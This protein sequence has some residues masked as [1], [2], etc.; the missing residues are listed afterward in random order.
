MFS[1]ICYSK[2]TTADT[3]IIKNNKIFDKTLLLGTDFQGRVI[4][5]LSTPQ[6][7]FRVNK[8][9]Q[10]GP[11]FFPAFWWNYETGEMDTKMGVGARADY[12]RN[13]FGINAFKV[14]KTW[15][16]ALMIG[17]KF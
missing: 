3:T 5:G 12:Q 4:V 1:H 17:Y 14:G 7:L 13:I 15:N 2:S 8:K 11:A 6:L 10:I 16:T 9:F